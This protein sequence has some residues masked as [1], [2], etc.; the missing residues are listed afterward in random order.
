MESN[1]SSLRPYYPTPTSSWVGFIHSLLFGVFITWFLWYFEPFKTGS[2]TLLKLSVFGL[3]S[4]FVFFVGHTLLPALFPRIYKESKWTIY[5]QIVFYLILTFCIATLNGLYI[6]YMFDLPFRW[7]NYALIIGQTLG[8]GILP[9]TI[10]VLL[11]YLWR[12]QQALRELKGLNADSTAQPAEPVRYTIETQSKDE[13]FD[14]SL[15]S[16][17][18]AES[19]GNYVIVREIDE[20][21]KIY[22]LSLSDFEQQ[23]SMADEILR[24]H[25]S[26]VV[27]TS[28]VSDLTGNAQ[29]LKLWFDHTVEAVPVSRKYLQRIKRRFQD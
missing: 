16:F 11:T 6:N 14:V 18:Y 19:S 29:G 5:H 1:R 20:Q 3:I 22:R 8:V 12:N 4:F 9:I 26:Y 27:N 24:C 7:S 10:Y 28:L 13:S 15:D 2:Y 17:L 23:L 25:R 21:K